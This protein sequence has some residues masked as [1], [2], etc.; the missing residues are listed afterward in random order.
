MEEVDVAG[1]GGPVDDFPTGGMSDVVITL[2]GFLL[3]LLDM[4][5]RRLCKP[6]GSDNVCEIG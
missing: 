4:L 2:E 6:P 1:E 5:L 3:T